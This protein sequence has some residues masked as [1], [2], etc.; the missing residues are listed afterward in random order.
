MVIILGIWIMR[1]FRTA[2]AAL[3]LAAATQNNAIAAPV[4]DCPLRDTAFSAASPM[5]DILLNPTASALIEKEMPG[6]LQKLPP[7]FSATTPPSFAA[8]VT[9]PQ[10]GAFVQASPEMISRVSAALPAIPVTDA[11]RV[12]RCA[13]YDNDKPT[14]AASKGKPRLLMFEKINGFRDGPSVDAAHKAFMDMAAA[15]GWS[16]SVTEKGGAINAA[17]L[18]QFDAIIWNNISGDVLT[19]AQRRALQKYMARGGGFIAV[20]GSAGDPTYF[21]DWFVDTLIGARFAGHPNSPQFQDARLVVEA[22]D[23]PVTAGLPAEWVMNDEWYSFK[24]NPRAAGAT[25]LATLD[26]ASYK[27]IGWPG[28]NLVMGDHPIAWT[29][30]VGKGRMFYA[31]I[32]HRPETY[33]EQHYAT[34]LRSATLWAATNKKACRTSGT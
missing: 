9:L 30:C 1:T 4:T 29:K 26:E 3:A 20:H 25:I 13:R 8:I 28:V 15:N 32:G 18:R 34:M 2:V 6:M 33:T 16:I 27:Q 5:I 19:L 17:T 23:H 7:M 31:A 11:D 24:T 10:A 21:W 12:A 22:K 14:F